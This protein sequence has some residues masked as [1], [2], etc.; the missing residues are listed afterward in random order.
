MADKLPQKN[1]DSLNAVN[2]FGE[3]RIAGVD[4]AG[5][6]P[7]AGPVVTAAVILDPQR[8]ITGLADSKALTARR[9]ERLAEE[10]R[11]K[12]WIALGI[13]EP[14]EIDRLNILHATMTAMARAVSRLPIAPDRVLIDGNRVPDG[15]PCPAEALV[16][17][18][19]REPVISAA[20]IIAKTVRDELMQSAALRY[21]GY[22][23]EQ[24]KGYPSAVHRERL[25][26]LGPCPIHRLSFAPV[27]A[28]RESE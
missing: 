5:R 11:Q 1:E 20:S 4:E 16:K 9:R 26:M 3:P 12:A 10:I 23:F 18:D 19:A 2:I 8:P 25:R 14:A 27:R 7:L 6:G 21:P 17:G 15:L 22:G 13:A 28:A 24:H